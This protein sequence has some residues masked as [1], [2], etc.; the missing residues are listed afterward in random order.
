MVARA[1]LRRFSNQQPTGRAIVETAA[2]PTGA[3]YLFTSVLWL[4]F[5]AD[6]A[7]PADLS[8]PLERT[9]TFANTFSQFGKLL[10][11][12]YQSSSNSKRVLAAVRFVIIQKETEEG[13]F[14]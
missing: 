10:R 13:R 12:E 6:T 4:L 5:S 2:G 14:V 8:C 1:N 11:G 7:S 9:D 3:A